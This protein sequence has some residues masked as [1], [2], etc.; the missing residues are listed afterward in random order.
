MSAP[1]PT[2]NPSGARRQHGAIALAG[3]QRARVEPLVL[4][5]GA[6][7][8]AHGQP[9]AVA[10]EHGSSFVGDLADVASWL[11]AY[12]FARQAELVRAH[13]RRVGIMIVCALA[14]GDTYVSILVGPAE[15]DA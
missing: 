11:D 14:S 7:A 15:G 1:Q 8:L 9:A 2:W 13:D 12:D 10:I 6:Y 4:R 3:H 5:A